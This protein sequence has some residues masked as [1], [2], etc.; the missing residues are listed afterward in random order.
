MKITIWKRI[1]STSRSNIT[2]RS[3]H[4]SAGIPRAC[5]EDLLLILI[6]LLLIFIILIFILILLLYWQGA[7]T[8]YRRPSS[9]QP[10]QRAGTGVV[11]PQP[12]TLSSSARPAALPPACEEG[13]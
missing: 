2:T 5:I 7:R 8:G 3:S 9:R 6:S 13:G 10:F 4:A 12:V 1:K 11:S